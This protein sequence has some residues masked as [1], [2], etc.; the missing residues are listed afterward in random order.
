VGAVRKSRPARQVQL[1]VIVIR[2]PPLHER[3][4]DIP[5]LVGQFL[6][7]ASSRAG[8]HVD[9]T[10]AAIESLTG[11]PRPG[12]HRELENTVERLVLFS[13]GTAIGVSDLPAA[14]HD[15]QPELADTLFAGLPALEEIE[16]RYL[17]HVLDWVGG[18]RT[19]A[20]EIMGIDRR[21]LYR[22]AERFGLDLEDEQ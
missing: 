4:A 3:R 14:F 13:R 21:T 8:R 12:N 19:R 1:S 6:L 17:L 9:L 10:P 18:D 15:A 2:V 20:A 11:H 22:M 7:N 16:R 5:L